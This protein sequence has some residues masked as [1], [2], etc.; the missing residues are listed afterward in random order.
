MPMSDDQLRKAKLK[1]RDGMQR[2]ARW[3]LRRMRNKYIGSPRA[4]RF[5]KQV[6]AFKSLLNEITP[7]K[8]KNLDAAQREGAL[9][10]AHRWC[11]RTDDVGRQRD[12]GRRA[13]REPP[14]EVR[15]RT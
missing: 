10:G 6:R 2:L 11:E 5:D 4:Y 12:T 9:R 7:E 15:R 13:K 14:R 3:H 8:Y 1:M